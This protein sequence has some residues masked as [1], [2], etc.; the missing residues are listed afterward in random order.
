[1]AEIERIIARLPQFLAANPNA[2]SDRSLTTLTEILATLS[3]S[4]TL[5]NDLEQWVFS[6]STA[7]KQSLLGFSR[8]VSNQPA[9]P[10]NTEA[11]IRQNLLEACQVLEKQKP[12]NPPPPAP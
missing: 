8:E 1:M 10:A 2:L 5:R 4:T 6:L 3:Q 7:E 9:L 11:E 12:Q